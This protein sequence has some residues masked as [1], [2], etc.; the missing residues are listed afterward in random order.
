MV[1]FFSNLWCC[2][3]G[4][5][6]QEELATFGYR[7]ERKVEKLKNHAVVWWFAGTYS[8][9]MAISENFPS[10][11]CRFGTFIIW[12]IFF[13][14]NPLYD[15]HWI[16]L[17]CPSDKHSPRKKH[18]SH[19]NEPYVLRNFYWTFKHFY[20]LGNSIQKKMVHIFV[21]ISKSQNF[22]HFHIYATW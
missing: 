19:V 12:H 10:K 2:H 13:P 6:P 22:S 5:H 14:K 9:N 7:S 17:S 3:A 11:P 4:D 21:E 8:L 16:L 20:S 18:W 1:S 15:S